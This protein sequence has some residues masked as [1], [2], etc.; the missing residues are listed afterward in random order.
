M[1]ALSGT[2][3]ARQRHKPSSGRTTACCIF[4]GVLYPKTST[5]AKIWR[6][7]FLDSQYRLFGMGTVF[8]R[9]QSRLSARPVS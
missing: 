4:S 6:C 8:G 9:I 5:K 1:S 2:L 3:A 7:Y